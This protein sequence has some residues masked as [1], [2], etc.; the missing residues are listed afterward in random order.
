MSKFIENEVIEIDDK[1]IGIVILNSKKEKFICK[2]D[3]EDY[4]RVR[5]FKWYMSLGYAESK[6]FSDTKYP[7]RAKLHRLIM[8]FPNGN[9]I[10]HI[11]GDKLDNRKS[12][13]RLCNKS[14]NGMN[15]GTQSN[16]KVG[17]KGVTFVRVRNKFRATIF[18]KKQ[19]HLGFFNTKE[20]AG[21]AYI[22]A[23]IKYFKEFS[24]KDGRTLGQIDQ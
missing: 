2:I 1:V 16:N 22:S 15:R 19:I 7:L 8:S 6:A 24:F 5:M 12:N 21:N 4:R 17:I 14:S 13:L 3:S 20:E 9:L 11:N 10:D 18:Y 23:S